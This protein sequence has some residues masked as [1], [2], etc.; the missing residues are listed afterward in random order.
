MKHLL[1]LLLA[2][3]VTLPA[4][5]QEWQGKSAAFFGVTFLDTSNEGSLN[6]VRAD[7][8]ARLAMIKAYIAEALRAQGLTLLDLAP[9]QEELDR[10]VNPAKCN[11]CD[12]RMAKRLGADYTVVSEVQKVSNLI[13]SMNLY[14]KDTATGKQ[15][16]GQAVDIRGNTDDSW[17]R[18]MRYI[19]TRNVF[20]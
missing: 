17:T 9:V 19:L 15:L 4:A 10:T 20:K 11:G 16:R 14:I 7:E 6:G 8:T 1:A 2:A 3:S 13:L 18:G 12:L 5:A